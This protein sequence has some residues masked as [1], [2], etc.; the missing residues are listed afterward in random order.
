MT[1]HQLNVTHGMLN[2]V[3]KLQVPT[4]NG[5]KDYF[6]WRLPYN[7]MLFPISFHFNFFLI[8]NPYPD[9]VTFYLVF[10]FGQHL[11]WW[12]GLLPIALWK[13]PSHNPLQNALIKNALFKR[14]IMNK[15]ILSSSIGGQI[16][17][18]MWN[19]L[20]LFQKCPSVF[21]DQMLLLKCPF[22]KGI[23]NK[24]ILSKDIGG[25]FW[26]GKRAFPPNRRKPKGLKLLRWG[27][28][29]LPL[30]HRVKILQ[31]IK[32]GTSHI[33]HHTSYIIYYTGI[34]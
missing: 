5:F 33:T 8:F 14:G 7:H 23:L 29:G 18:Q 11:L 2:T 32:S 34:C 16:G 17:E 13:M 26:K 24:G 20:L 9:W 27:I 12:E 15:S 19:A 31:K 22:K 25:N 30:T 6:V 4:F 10:S 21:L 1:C 28:F 3:L